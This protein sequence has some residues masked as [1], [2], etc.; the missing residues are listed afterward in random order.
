MVL[1]EAHNAHNMVGLVDGVV[2]SGSGVVV[3]TADCS[4]G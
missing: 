2:S 3:P 1:A 4:S